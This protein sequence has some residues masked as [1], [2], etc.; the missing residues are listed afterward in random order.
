MSPLLLERSELRIRL[1]SNLSRRHTTN[2]PPMMWKLLRTSVDC[3]FLMQIS[4]AMGTRTLVRD[5]VTNSKVRPF[6]LVVSDIMKNAE[7]GSMRHFG[8]MVSRRCCAP[9]WTLRGR[10]PRARDLQKLIL[11]KLNQL[12]T[13]HLLS[14]LWKCLIFIMM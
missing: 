3:R 10:R 8:M 9:I 12:W 6:W 11:W 7:N 2:L 5:A 4:C 1:R 13:K 14:L